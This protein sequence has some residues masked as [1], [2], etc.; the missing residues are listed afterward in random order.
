MFVN[1]V[2]SIL[3][4]AGI[5]VGSGFTIKSVERLSKTLKMS[6]FIVSFIVLGVFTSI[7]ELSVGINS[8]I[9]DDPEIYVGNLI[10][11]SMVIFLFIIPILAITGRSI[12]IAPEFRGFNLPATLV[13]IA[14]PVLLSLDGRLGR[15][16]SLIVFILFAIMLFSLHG[17]RGLV[18][19]HIRISN[20][21][22]IKASKDLI[23][24]I[25][26][27]AIIFIGSRFVVEQTI[28]FS[29]F[30][31]I[32]PFL[33]SL[34]VISIGTNIPEISLVI[35]SI[36]MRNKQVAFGN[37]MGSASFNT[38]LLGGLTFVYG[39]PVLLQNS[40]VVSL[41]FLIVGLILFYL[42]AKTKHEISRAEGF[43]LL[44]LYVLFIMAE[45]V[46]H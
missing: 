2:I 14:L 23:R 9:I 4:F 10:G 12:R 17:K 15:N 13:V 31:N 35:R 44:I 32:S 28:Y 46:M 38:F 39:K 26:G 42:F 19:H 6:S 27:V 30:F 24:I 22:G 29:N 25:F 16:D 20:D 36:F 34:L 1:F 21:A 11:A 45:I 41:L 18:E 7:G 3:A 37:Y 8:I 43:V 40:Y 33:I 5:W